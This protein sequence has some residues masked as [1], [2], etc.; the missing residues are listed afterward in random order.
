GLVEGLGME[1]LEYMDKTMCCGAGVRGQASDTSFAI[2]K[3]KLTSMMMV[4]P[5]AAVVFCPTCFI[6]FE[7][8]QRIVNR[9]FG[10]SFKLP[11]YY[12]TELL[13]VAMDLSDVA[14]VLAGHRVKPD[15]PLL[16][17]VTQETETPSASQ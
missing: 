15:T 13:A 9:M 7:A 8:G 12:Y 11:V 5:D 14:N 4:N 16:D 3:E 17:S 2:L 1:A 6:S 10:T